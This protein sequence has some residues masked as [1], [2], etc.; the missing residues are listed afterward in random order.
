MNLTGVE[1]CLQ[2][3]CSELVDDNDVVIETDDYSLTKRSFERLGANRWLN[4]EC[5]N[6]FVS[7]INRRETDKSKDKHPDTFA[8]NTFFY[9]M[10]EDMRVSNSYNFR[11]LQRIVNKKKIN[12]RQL[13]NILIPINIRDYHW[14]LF[15]CNLSSNTFY[16]IDSM[17][18]SRQEAS[19]HIETIK[20]FLQDYFHATKG[21]IA[22]SS[23]KSLH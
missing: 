21:E 12:L 3:M 11:K 7:L 22:S 16:I 17:G 13:K 14:L 4:D 6:A 2:A 15:D 8:F 20:Q 19:H 10:L 1:E 23:R 18:S 5:I 9:T